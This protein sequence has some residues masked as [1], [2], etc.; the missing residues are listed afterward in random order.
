MKNCAKIILVLVLM[1]L[2]IANVAWAQTNV[3]ALQGAGA[4]GMRLAQELSAEGQH[5][6][7]ALEY[8]RLALSETKAQARGGLFWVAAY[9]YTQARQW[10]LAPALLD[11]A[12][13]CDH[14][15]KP[16]ALLLRAEV[17][18]AEKKHVEAVYYLQSA[19]AEGTMP[20]MRQYVGRR[21]AGEQ[22]RAGQAAQARLALSQTPCW[23]AAR[24]STPRSRAFSNWLRLSAAA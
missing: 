15:L 12:E 19:V 17:A 1:R 4:P 22:L 6:P 5:E 16:V 10:S 18:S 14:A 13:D 24:P 2:I 11:R 8:R 21:V 9:E 3:P 23:H 20:E 7:A